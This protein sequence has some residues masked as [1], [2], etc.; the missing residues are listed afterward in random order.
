MSIEPA[1]TTFGAPP[2]L[3]KPKLP[4]VKEVWTQLWADLLGKD[5]QDTATF[6]YEWVADQTGHFALGFELTYLLSWIAAVAG[7]KDGRVGFW[8]G[9]AV[10]IVFALKETRDYYSTKA[11]AEAAKSVFLFNGKEVAWNCVTAVFYIG[12]GALV[13]ALALLNPLFGIISVFA[14]FPFIAWMGYSWL[15]VKVTFQQAGVPYLYRLANFP[16]PQIGKEIGEFIVAMTKPAAPGDPPTTAYHLL[17]AGPLDSG[18]SSLAV[19]IGSEYGIRMGIGRYTT[20]AK[21]LQEALRKDH[22]WD[23]PEFND[24]RILWPWQTSDLLIVDDVD[25]LS[26]H[27]R[28]DDAERERA[29]AQQRANVLKAQIPGEI[30]KALKF[31]RT[32][33]VVGDVDDGELNRWRAMLADIIGVPTDVVRYVRL[34]D[35]IDA[36]P[37]DRPT[38]TAR[39]KS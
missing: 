1:P 9:I 30:Q 7:Y 29:I 23:K 26:D 39:V 28:G 34:Q 17:I 38:P 10:I 21:L 5:V 6:S 4:G 37:P 16:S 13:A 3:P 22:E 15:R 20:W 8:L 32:C 31:R 25:V 12:I 19:G 18:K 36:L 35:K 14:T 2:K 33:W 24:G 27:F 11:Q